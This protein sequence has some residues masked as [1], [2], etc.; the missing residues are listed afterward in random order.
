MRKVIACFAADTDGSTA[1]EYSLM[2]ASVA[3]GLL[4]AIASLSE[5][6]SALFGAI[7]AGLSAI[8]SF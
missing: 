1:L 2:I 3:I 8:S 4:L 7:S 5:E 6:L